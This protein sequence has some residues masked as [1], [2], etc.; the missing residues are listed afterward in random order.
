[1]GDVRIGGGR[2][3]QGSALATHFEAG[4]NRDGSEHQHGEG[5]DKAGPAAPPQTGANQHADPTHVDPTVP[6]DSE[7]TICP[8]RMWT[9]RSDTAATSTSWVTITMV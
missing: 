1:M 2:V 4:G 8:S 7:L 3:E 9:I 6:D 5:G